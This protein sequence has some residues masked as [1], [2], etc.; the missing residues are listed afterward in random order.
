MGGVLAASDS[1]EIP[2]NLQEVVM[3]KRRMNMSEVPRSCYDPSDE[4]AVVMHEA[5]MESKSA[6]VVAT[7]GQLNDW[8]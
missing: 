6:V 2:E 8:L 1:C 4:L 5:L 3:L 7:G